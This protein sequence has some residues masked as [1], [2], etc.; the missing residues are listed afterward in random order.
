MVSVFEGEVINLETIFRDQ[1]A[2]LVDSNYDFV[3]I[4]DKTCKFIWN[5]P[6]YQVPCSE[7]IMDNDAYFMVLRYFAVQKGER[8]GILEYQ[9][10]NNFEV[11]TM[12]CLKTIVLKVE[13]PC[14]CQHF[15]KGKSKYLLV[16]SHL[17]TDFKLFALRGDIL[18]EGTF[19]KILGEGPY[20][21]KF[22]NILFKFN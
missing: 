5:T 8:T 9:E 6:Y 1:G 22:K 2:A 15:N 18:K 20:V 16:K 11:E 12:S 21:F 19:Y 7:D 3:E 4:K 17:G 14:Y 13:K 10:L